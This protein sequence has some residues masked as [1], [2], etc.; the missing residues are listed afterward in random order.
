MHFIFQCLIC[1]DAVLSECTDDRLSDLVL[2]CLGFLS[3]ANRGALMTCA[4]VLWVLLGTPA[5]YVSA[6]LYKSKSPGKPLSQNVPSCCRQRDLSH[7]DILIHLCFRSQLLEVR[8]GRR[9]SCWLHSCAQGKSPSFAP[10]HLSHLWASFLPWSDVL[11]CTCSFGL[12]PRFYHSHMYSLSM[13][14]R[15]SISPP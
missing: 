4:V 13:C 6:R 10:V 8:S 9:T 15:S 12:G 7:R 1:N 3:P 2:A 5:G 14:C 11:R